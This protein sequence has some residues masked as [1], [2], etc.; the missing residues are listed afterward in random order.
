MKIPTFIV[1]CAMLKKVLFRKNTL[2]YSLN[3]KT[4]E[5][6]TIWVGDNACMTAMR[7]RLNIF[8]NHWIAQYNAQQQKVN[9]EK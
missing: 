2:M 9:K 3:N 4:G 1:K 8:L 6:Q 7:N 5:I